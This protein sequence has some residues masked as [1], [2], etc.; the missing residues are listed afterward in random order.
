MKYTWFIREEILKKGYKIS[1][2]S[3]SHF[4]SHIHKIANECGLESSC[5]IFLMEY[6]KM[7]QINLN[8]IFEGW[9]MK[10]I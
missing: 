6:Y 4:I 9:Q 5:F 10:D 3:E 2:Q 7:H 8:Y 1:E